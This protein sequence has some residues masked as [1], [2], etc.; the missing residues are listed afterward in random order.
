MNNPS[1]ES[2][3]I[4]VFKYYAFDHLLCE[5]LAR[6]VASISGK[7]RH[8]ASSNPI[9]PHLIYLV[10]LLVYLYTYNMLISM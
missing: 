1:L 6:S 4:V 10:Y 2:Y 3:Y 8:V 7:T 9:Q 5:I